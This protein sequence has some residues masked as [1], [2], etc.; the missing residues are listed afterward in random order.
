[1]AEI[2]TPD[3]EAELAEAVAEAAGAGT[4][5]E[6]R[7]GGTRAGLGRPV[8]ASRTLSTAGLSGITLYEPGAL[9]LVVKAGTPMAEVEAALA[10]EGQM[11]PF[12]PIDHRALLGAQGEPTIGGVV[13]C[14][15][16]GPR[17]IQAGA[18]RDAMLGV[19]FVN[20][21]G[22]AVKSGGRVMKNVTGYDL[23]KLMC[24][25]HGTL[26]VLSEIS[27]KVLPKPEAEATLVREGLDAGAGVAA[28]NAALASPFGITGAAHLDARSLVRIDGLAGSVAYRTEKL[29][30][31][32]GAGWEAVSGAESA[33]L[34]R[35]V[36]D[37]APFAGRDGAVWRISVKPAAGPVLSD[38]LSTAGLDHA[39]LYD[40]GGGLV[41]LL[42]AETGDAGAGL[43]RRA[44]AALG[45][46]ASLVRASAAT[47]AAVEVFEP[48][49]EPLA[50]ISAGLRVKFDPAGILNPGRMR[51]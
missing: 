26:G 36:R 37:V 2:I 41:W 28:L 31:L 1:M 23:V 20:G 18:C 40:W 34:W 12:E 24:G 10:A 38:E 44:T 46:H 27:F 51:G 32:L 9:T 3:D 21:R 11:L 35:A 16:S 25:S 15:V 22:E 29:L 6:I 48:E 17:R 50:R 43:V 47:R 5:L 39:A 33:A 8:Q 42:T 7:G 14:G 4:P 13:A 45:G 30:D 49:P 19:R